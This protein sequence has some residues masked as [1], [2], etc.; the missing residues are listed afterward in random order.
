[1]VKVEL[2]SAFSKDGAGGNPAGVVFDAAG[3]SEE[4]MQ[5]IAAQVGYSETAFVMPSE[6]AEYQVRFS[7]LLMR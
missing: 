2:I 1:M 3:L 7:R 6:L 4:N 5:Q